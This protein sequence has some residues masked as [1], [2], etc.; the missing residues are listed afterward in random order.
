MIGP[1]AWFGRFGEHVVLHRDTKAL[2]VAGAMVIVAD[3][4]TGKA[5]PTPTAQARVRR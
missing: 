3:G 2:A 4:N 5:H 1:A